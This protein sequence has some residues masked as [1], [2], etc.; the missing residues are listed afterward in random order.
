MKQSFFNLF[1]N[2][3]LR[4][5][6]NK[7][8][9]PFKAFDKIV[10]SRN[11]RENKASKGIILITPVRIS[12]ISNLFEGLIGKFYQLKG[13]D[14][15]VLL[16]N[17]SVLY[18]ENFTKYRNKYIAC[19][20]CKKEQERFANLFNLK[21]IKA[22]DCITSPEIKYIQQQIKKRDFK[23][24]E[25]F[26]FNGVNLYDSIT[27]AVM[28]YTLRSEIAGFE[29]LIKK[30]A[31][32]SFFY[33]TVISNINKNFKINSLITSHGIYSTWGSILAT[34]KK[35]NI[36]SVIWG[37]GYIGQGKLLFGINQSYHEEF[38]NESSKYYQ[39]IS[40]DENKIKEVK[41]YFNKKMDPNSK[42]DYINY[43]QHLKNK[44]VVNFEE[45]KKQINS[46]KTTFGMFTNIP[47]DGEM[48]KTSEAFPT[49]R[50]YIGSVIN[51]FIDHKDCLL[52]IRAHPAEITR[53]SS[54]GT[55]TFEELLFNEFP[56]FPDNI[57]FLPPDSSITSY[58]IAELV[59]AIVLFGSTMS[60]ELAIQ[61]RLVI[62][63]GKNNVSYKEI[64][65]DALDQNTLYDY[66]D[67]VKR[68]ELKTTE[69]MYYNALKYGHYWIYKRHI[70][71][72]S[73]KLNK[74]S[75]QN[76][77]FKNEKEFME[78]KTLNFLY[79]KINKKER[80]VY[81]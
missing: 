22:N 73:V 47:W 26:I 81:E 77:N 33:S 30:Y 64:V 53:G 56:I 18:C 12:P 75:F 13:Y 43:Y 3:F 70:E 44:H 80:I 39:N 20:L 38:I 6:Y 36:H 66:L 2:L 62:Q 1:A 54:K 67:K 63:S 45:L 29:N 32:T 69:E 35:L 16:C 57:Q 7:I 79:N 51:W 15:R 49:T 59:D 34:C 48:L 27:S 72:T 46:Y 78:D 24:K 17:Q 50:A 5:R 61:K 31:Y 74:L 55:E 10:N 40:L 42:V 9:D 52:I 23:K 21:V 4:I 60:L 37:R 11:S 41:A 28:R 68:R 19:A 8:R 58:A 65:Y 71:D 76:Y 14:V 25:D